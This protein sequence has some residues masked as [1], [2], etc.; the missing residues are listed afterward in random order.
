M[1]LTLTDAIHNAVDELTT[2]QSFST[3]DVTR[4]IRY[5]VN[6][7]RWTI[8]ECRIYGEDYDYQIYHS[9][10]R[11]LFNDFLKSSDC[12]NLSVTQS[13]DGRYRVY[14]P[15]NITFT[16]MA[17]DNEFARRVKVYITNCQNRGITPK[18]NDIR[19]AIKRGKHA[20][21]LTIRQIYDIVKNL[22][23]DNRITK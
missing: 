3:W 9:D 2:K 20:T 21:G 16:D 15:Y 4:Y 18:L 13:L 10:I 12:P 1:Q 8:P 6:S 22:G 5:M 14:M 11:T 23:Y 19:R 7:G 17:Y